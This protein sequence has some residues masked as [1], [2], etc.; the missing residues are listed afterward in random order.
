M[1]EDKNIQWNTQIP[2]SIKLK[3][4][5]FMP[6]HRQ[7][8]SSTTS[9][10]YYHH[11]KQQ[12]AS[13]IDIP[14]AHREAFEEQRNVLAANLKTFFRQTE[15]IREWATVPWRRKNS[16]LFEG[17]FCACANHIDLLPTWLI[18]NVRAR[19]LNRRACMHTYAC[20]ARAHAQPS[21]A[22][23][24]YHT[25]SIYMYKRKMSSVL[26]VPPVYTKKQATHQIFCA[27]S[28]PS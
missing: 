5:H 27:K 16:T 6:C 10:I 4:T 12:T 2:S 1:L 21:V 19:V 11:Q 22:Y 15:F 8:A 24:Y 25:V 3:N 9:S 26:C 17:F 7:P 18:G 28:Q 14:S 23:I 13:C 20:S